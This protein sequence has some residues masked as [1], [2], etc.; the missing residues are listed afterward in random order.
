MADIVR[1]KSFPSNYPNDAVAIL[2][3]MSFSDGENVILLGSNSLRSQLYSA[4]YDG[5]ETFLAKSVGELVKKFKEIIR[6]LLK[7]PNTFIGDIKCG[8]IEEWRIIPK[9]GWN[10]SL[11]KG[12]IERLYGNKILSKGEADEAL[13]LI[14]AGRSKLGK[15]NARDK[16]KYHIIR[17][18]PEQILKGKQTLR[19]GR[20]YTLEEALVAHTITKIDVISLIENNR[21]TDFSIIYNLVVGNKPLNPDKIDVKKSLEEAIVVLRAKGDLFKVL[22]RKYALAKFEHDVKKVKRLQILLNGDNGRIYQ[23]LSEIGTLID[24][25]ER[26]KTTAPIGTIRYELDQVKGKMALIYKSHKYLNREHALLKELNQMLEAPKADLLPM[27]EKFYDNF[28]AILNHET[29]KR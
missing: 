4:D 26:Y 25:L 9:A 11:S 7:M 1:E 20:V 3:A 22:K 16:L 29:P 5:Q 18:T 13:E 8:A 14:K 10:A 27:L 19:D 6:R 17:W 23:I 12:N 28:K 24:L 15:L 2:T 21:Y